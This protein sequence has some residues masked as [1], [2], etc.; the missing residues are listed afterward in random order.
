M[1]NLTLDVVRADD[2]LALSFEFVNLDFDTDETP[3][4]PRLVRFDPGEDAF[5]IV[6]FPPQHIAERLFSRRA[7]G[8]LTPQWA[9]A[10][11]FP[12]L[13]AGNS[14]LGFRLRPE[15]ESLSISLDELLNW[16]NFEPVFTLEAAEAEG[17]THEI[18]EPL[19]NETAIELPLRIV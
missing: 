9:S 3:V 10:G 13:I 11:P 5:V 7:D 18:T 14:R 2:L 17:S 8:T 16:D 12:S 1:G 4:L 19:A 15:V 6:H